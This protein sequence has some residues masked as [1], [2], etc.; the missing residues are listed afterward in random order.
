MGLLNDDNHK[1]DSRG[2]QWWWL[3]LIGIGFVLGVVAT[4][5]VRPARVETVVL[6]P[7]PTQIEDPQDILLTAVRAYATAAAGEN[8]N[9]NSEST[10]SPARLTATAMIGEVIQHALATQTANP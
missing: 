8:N 2:F 7:V 10:V 5:I 9:P 3:L 4:V 6:T 1:N